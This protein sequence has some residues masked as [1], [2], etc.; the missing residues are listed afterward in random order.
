VP[1][2]RLTNAGGS[3]SSGPGPKLI[4]V[5]SGKGG[6]GKSVLAYNLA[7]RI[8]ARGSKTLLVDADFTG[9]NLHILANRDCPV[10]TGEYAARKLSL[11]ETTIELADRLHLLGVA[12]EMVGSENVTASGAARLIERLRRDAEDFDLV[13][14]D[15]SSGRSEVATVMAHGSDLCLLVVVPELTS[16]SDAYGLCKYLRQSDASIDCRLLVNRAAS[17]EEADYIH[18]KLGAV[19]ERF[20]G[21]ALR[22]QG[23]VLEDGLVRESVASQSTLAGLNSNSVVVQELNRIAQ[24]LD[25]ELLPATSRDSRSPQIENNEKS[26]MADIRG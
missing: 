19:T 24:L 25:G 9:G 11:S 26:A 18:K 7:E 15:H 6:V 14:L 4:S 13:V 10:G 16:I 12:P 17:A 23:F 2:L 8:A 1:K 21:E 20:L 22:C 5:L 3:S